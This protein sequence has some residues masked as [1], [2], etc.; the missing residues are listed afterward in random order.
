MKTFF[1]S[2]LSR[3]KLLLLGLV[4][5][6]ALWWLSGVIGRA[7]AFIDDWKSTTTTLESQQRMLDAREKIQSRATAAIQQLDPSRT[8]DT[9]RLQEELN[10]VATMAGI[11]NK[12]IGDLR[13]EKTTIFSI[14][15]AQ[16]QIRNAD[17]AMLVKF[18]EEL[19][20]RSPYIGLDQLT[21]QPSTPANPAQ[22]TMQAKVSSVEIAR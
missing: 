3:E 16:V 22:L 19:K 18:Y 5:M 6:A 2:R 7:T 15:S 20:K 14:N 21:V 11:G 13:S 8:F 1:L 17:Y 10:T 9:W 4:L 12:N